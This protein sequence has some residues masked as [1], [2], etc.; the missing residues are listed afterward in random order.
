MDTYKS[1]KGQILNLD[2]KDFKEVALRVFRYQAGNN[3]VYRSFLENLG[4]DPFKVESLRQIPF[5]PIELFKSR[6]IKT[7]IWKQKEV[8]TSS[9]SGTSGASRHF[10]YS[11]EYYHN[12]C[13]KIFEDFYGPLSHYHILALLPNYL[14]RSGS[15]LISMVTHFI[16]KTGSSYS[17]FYLRNFRELIKTLDATTRDNSRKTLLWGV[18]FALLDL[19]RELSTKYPGLVIIETGGMKGRREEMVR[20]ELHEIL[21]LSFGTLKVHSEYGMAEL[22][23]QAYAVNQGNFLGPPWMKIFIR[24]INDPMDFCPKGR[25]GGINV[26]DLGNLH[27]CAFIETQDLGMTDPDGAFQVLGRMDNSEMRGCNLMVL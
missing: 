3:P 2:D 20:E 21:K 4:Q 5:L 8:F 25:V 15:S 11:T 27:S 19:A 24:D 22:T 9:G 17:G 16:E 1:L 18:P 7:G 13:R 6:V 14:E 12:V 26:I 10:I 23:S